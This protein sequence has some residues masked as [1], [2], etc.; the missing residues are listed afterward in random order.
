MKW[1]PLHFSKI[2]EIGGLCRRL[3]PLSQLVSAV[4][5]FMQF[6]VL[7]HLIVN[8]FLNQFLCFD[9]SVSTEQ[10][11]VNIHTLMQLHTP[12]HTIL[13]RVR[14][15][16][17]G[18]IAVFGDS[19]CGLTLF[20]NPDRI[21]AHEYIFV[22]VEE[23]IATCGLFDDEHDLVRRVCVSLRKDYMPLRKSCN[24]SRYCCSVSK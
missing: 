14:V 4:E 16:N 6:E 8:E 2:H 15:T 18:T 10:T 23:I 9:N 11:L 24:S 22:I 21:F 12:V 13:W 1:N 7:C 20:T 3:V 5:F 17:V 19:E